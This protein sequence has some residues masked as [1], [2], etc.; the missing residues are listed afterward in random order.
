MLFRSFGYWLLIIFSA[1]VLL[2]S[3]FV[4]SK[5]GLLGEPA[6]TWAIWVLSEF[7]TLYLPNKDE[8]EFAVKAIGAMGTALGAAWTIHKGWHYAEIRLPARLAEF[9]ERWK[10]KLEQDLPTRIPA[11]A[12]VISIAFEPVPVP[13]FLMR[14]VSWIHDPRQWAL[15]RGREIVT[16]SR[17]DLKLLT[18]SRIRCQAELVLAHLDVAAHLSRAGKSDDALN[19]FKEALKV[20]STDVHALELTARQ[21]FALG[22][23]GLARQHLQ[24]LAKLSER[25]GDVLRRARAMR[26]EAE[27][28]KG[29]G[30]GE[31]EQARD[32]LKAVIEILRDT[33]VKNDKGKSIELCLAYGQLADVQRLRSVLFA[34]RNALDLAHEHCERLDHGSQ[35][36]TTQWLD[37]IDKRLKIAEQGR[38]RENETS[39]DAPPSES[40]KPSNNSPKK[41]G[42]R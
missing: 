21:A 7:Y 6:R 28:L 17:E 35:N 5:M 26:F 40:P 23:S 8:I 29:G 13:S 19:E 22:Q 16:N 9:N 37:D 30:H 15:A 18:A 1:F 24:K 10:L 11:L 25:S 42:K 38:D 33:S 3:V 4:S 34:A 27:I 31:P 20:S 32:T 2:V 14:L 36:R 39:D 41:K 12:D